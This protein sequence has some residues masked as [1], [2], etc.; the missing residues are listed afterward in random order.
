[1]QPL[2]GRPLRDLQYPDRLSN[3]SYEI[4]SLATRLVG[5]ASP[6]MDPA[7]K[8]DQLPVL[9]KSRLPHIYTCRALPGMTQSAL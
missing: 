8:F 5:L 3:H 9:A 7:A 1:M 2:G 4:V 6:G